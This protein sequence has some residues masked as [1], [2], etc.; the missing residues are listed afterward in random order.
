MHIELAGTLELDDIRHSFRWTRRLQEDEIRAANP[1]N[2]GVWLFGP[3]FIVVAVIMGMGGQGY[4]ALASALVGLLLL[5]P[6]LAYLPWLLYWQYSILPGVY[7]DNLALFQLRWRLDDLG[8]DVLDAR[9]SEQRHPW[10]DYRDYDE[11]GAGFLL[12]WWPLPGVDPDTLGDREQVVHY[13][14]RRFFTPEQA[15]EFSAFLAKKFAER[16]DERD[17]APAASV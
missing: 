15:L 5:Y 7:R 17:S 16:G 6:A 12:Y 10:S 13:L 9:P 8:V 14:P 1:M 3:F 2:L 4:L 11:D